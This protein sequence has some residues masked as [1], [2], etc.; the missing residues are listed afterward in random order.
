MPSDQVGSSCQGAF[1]STVASSEIID[2]R[3]VLCTLNWSKFFIF[4][5]NTLRRKK[6][7]SVKQWRT[8]KK[9]EIAFRRCFSSLSRIFSVVVCW[10]RASTK[11][12]LPLNV[13]ASSKCL[14]PDSSMNSNMGTFVSLLLIV[15]S[16]WADNVK[17]D[18]NGSNVLMMLLQLYS[19]QHVTASIWCCS[20][21]K[22]KID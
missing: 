6:K 2:F 18:E 7:T 9:N 13:Y 3:Q 15:C 12:S 19:S 5:S 14:C 8:K 1:L 11:L 17:S 4:Q 16:M 20:K 22:E 10:P 21:T